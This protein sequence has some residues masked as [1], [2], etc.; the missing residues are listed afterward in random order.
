[1][2]LKQTTNGV[3]PVMLQSRF[4]CEGKNQQN[5]QE[6]VTNIITSKGYQSKLVKEEKGVNLKAAVLV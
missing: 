4:Y 2:F 5:Y 3:P 6:L 1:M